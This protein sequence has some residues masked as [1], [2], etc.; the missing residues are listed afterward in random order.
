MQRLK[1]YLDKGK[2]LV[3]LV[4]DLSK[5]IPKTIEKI[6]EILKD[7]VENPKPQSPDK[8][9]LIRMI[10]SLQSL[11]LSVLA[12]LTQGDNSFDL[13]ALESTILSV[14]SQ[15]W[16]A[17]HAYPEGLFAEV[18]S[19][20]LVTHLDLV[21][22]LLQLFGLSALHPKI[23]RI[24]QHLANYFG[25]SSLSCSLLRSLLKAIGSSASELVHGFIIKHQILPGLFKDLQIL[26]CQEK[27]TLGLCKKN[28]KKKLVNGHQRRHHKVVMKITENKILKKITLTDEGKV[29]EEETLGKLRL[30]ALFLQESRDIE[31]DL[32]DWFLLNVDK[33]PPMLKDLVVQ[34]LFNYVVVSKKH[35][36]KLR[37][38]LN[39]MKKDLDIAGVCRHYLFILENLVNVT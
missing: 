31:V 20:V 36:K 10:E 25:S 14:I 3:E 39:G 23:F 33:L 15:S 29:N 5:N 28:S 22:K 11:L 1:E 12:S 18:K 35:L 30:L 7:L 2:D 9:Q 6:S 8:E 27:V 37:S 38:L 32:D 24:T 13:T 19:K 16:T 21:K 34:V 4:P 17:L 26:T